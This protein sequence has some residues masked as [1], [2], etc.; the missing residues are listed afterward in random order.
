LK[1]LAFLEGYFSTL[2]ERLEPCLTEAF[3]IFVGEIDCIIILDR[4]GR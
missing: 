2:F 1:D 3:L 4:G